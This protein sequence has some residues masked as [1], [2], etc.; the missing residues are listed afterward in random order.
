MLSSDRIVAEANAIL[1]GYSGWELRDYEI[2]VVHVTKFYVK[3]KSNA[4]L[5]TEAA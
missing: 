5:L 2:K 1:P 4:V 3:Q